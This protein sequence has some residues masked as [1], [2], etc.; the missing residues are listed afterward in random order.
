MREAPPPVIVERV[1]RVSSGQIW[2]AGYY[3]HDGH[4]FVWVRGHVERARPGYRYETV[5]WVR[6]SRGYERHGG[7]WIR[8]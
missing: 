4:R 5:R 8:H 3:R 1:P 7:V 6:T 2:I